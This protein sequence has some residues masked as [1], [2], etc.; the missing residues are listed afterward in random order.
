MVV[1]RC[2]GDRGWGLKVNEN[3]IK[4]TVL[5]GEERFVCQVIGW[6]IN[7]ACLGA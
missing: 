1:L 2:V 6:E 3:K 4:V 5:G 7:G